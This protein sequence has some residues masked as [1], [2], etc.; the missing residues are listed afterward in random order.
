MLEILVLVNKKEYQVAEKKM[1][2]YVGVYEIRK[3]I[4]NKMLIV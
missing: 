4:V 1:E 3:T 2:H